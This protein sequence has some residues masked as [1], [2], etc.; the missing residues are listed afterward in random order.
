MEEK[1]LAEAIEAWPRVDLEQWI[2]QYVDVGVYRYREG[3]SYGMN[4]SPEEFKRPGHCCSL[5]S[6]TG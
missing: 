2:S 1:A 5:Q 6:S 4:C 3:E